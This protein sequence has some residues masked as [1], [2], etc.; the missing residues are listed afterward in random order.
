P[1]GRCNATTAGSLV[2]RSRSAD[3]DSDVSVLTHKNLFDY[4]YQGTPNP[5]GYYTETGLLWLP[6]PRRWMLTYT[7]AQPPSVGGPASRVSCV[8]SSG[9]W[10]W[11]IHS[12]GTAASR[13]SL[14]GWGSRFRRGP[15][16]RRPHHGSRDPVGGSS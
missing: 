10:S 12:W 16:P 13:E 4:A 1:A 15:S 2:L 5:D 8:H 9:G 3:L 11:R 14:R 6:G 7:E